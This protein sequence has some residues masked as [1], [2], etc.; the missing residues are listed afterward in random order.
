[1]INEL[2][3]F[4]DIKRYALHDG[5][6]IRTTVFFK[7]CPL[8]CAWCQ[9]PESQARAPQL[10]LYPDLC[11]RCGACAEACPTTAIRTPRWPTYCGSS[12]RLVLSS[13]STAG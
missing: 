9:N 1:M 5:P 10:M 2:P 4:F 11:M 7:G 6:N 13:G 3:L 12:T 8:R